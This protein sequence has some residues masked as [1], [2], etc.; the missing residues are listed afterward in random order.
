LNLQHAVHGARAED[1]LPDTLLLVEHPHVLTFGR[2]AHEE[3]VLVSESALQQQGVTCVHIERGGDVTYHGPGQQLAY[4][5]FALQKCGI[6]VL[7]FVEKLEEVMIHILKDYGITGERSK[8]NRGVWVENKKIG[9]V[10]I[11]VQKGIAFHGLALNVD[12]DLKFFQMIN[13]CGLKEVQITSMADLLGKKVSPEKINDR[14]IF[15]FEKIFDMT[16]KQVKPNDLRA[17]IQEK[18]REE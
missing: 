13:P 15:H 2:R 7:D 12:P 11:A 18:Y 1:L 3:N 14:L 17:R 5:I 16:L 9:F 8:R 10:G 4:P 6:G